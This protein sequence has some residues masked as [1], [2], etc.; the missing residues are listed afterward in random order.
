MQFGAMK[1]LKLLGLA[2]LSALPTV[3]GD[4]TPEEIYNFFK[5]ALSPGSG[6]FYATDGNFS[7][8]VTPRWNAYGAPTYVIGIKPALETDVQIAV[9]Y[10]SLHHIDFLGTGGGHGY[11]TTMEEIK[12]GVEIDLGN[13]NS[14][15]IDKAANTMTGGGSIHF[16]DLTGPLQD[17]G[18]ELPIGSC[19]CVGAVGATLGGGIGAYTSKHGLIADS[20]LSVRMVTGTGDL[21]TVSANQNSDL[22]WGLK[23]AGFN[24]GIITQATYRIYNASNG[25]YAMNADLRYSAEYNESIWN[26]LKQFEHDQPVGLSF[27]LGIGWNSTTGET[28]F[29]LNA[30][31]AGPLEEGESLIKPFLDIP[32]QLKNITEIPWSHIEAE[33]RFGVDSYGC[34]KGRSHS[35]YGN[36][37]YSLDVP[38]L[39]DVTNYLD[40]SYKQYPPLQFS[41]FAMVQYGTTVMNSVADGTAAY[42]FRNVVAY[43]HFDVSFP[44]STWEAAANEVGTTTREKLYRTDGSATKDVFVNF[45]HGD[46]GPES[47]YTKRKLPRLLA[48][49]R[50]YDPHRVFTHYNG[51]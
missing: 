41:V 27:D 1:S 17:A 39:I 21:I 11:T 3:L 47:W 48:L 38:T 34:V 45:A 37:L 28:Y 30:I 12:A 44:N 40:Q 36:N 6:V 9:R 51:L 5:T 43:I 46:E 29:A 14:V 4:R 26:A 7:Q 10:L 33:S 19:T 13:F 23:G 32:I 31:W 49:K 24:F 2:A 20:L 35:V 50:K 22:F 8:E 15:A 42:A 16:R 25:G 18:K